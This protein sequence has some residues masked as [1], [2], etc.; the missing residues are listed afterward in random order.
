MF[1]KCPACIL[2]LDLITLTTLSEG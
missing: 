2:I 1:A